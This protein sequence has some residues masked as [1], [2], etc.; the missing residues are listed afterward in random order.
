[1]NG[2]IHLCTTVQAY[3]YSTIFEKGL[4]QQQFLGVAPLADNLYQRA[5]HGDKS[6]PLD[7]GCILQFILEP[8]IQR[9]TQKL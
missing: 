3:F 6:T 9:T 4:A 7:R 2:C 1:M 5:W 8:G